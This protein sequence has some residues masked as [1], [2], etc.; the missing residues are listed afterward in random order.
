MNDLLEFLIDLVRWPYEQWKRT[1]EN[2][3]VGTSPNEE[4]TLRFWRWFG[5]IGTSII[6]ILGAILYWAFRI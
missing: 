3:R 1:T 6:C 2:S 4:K 5:I